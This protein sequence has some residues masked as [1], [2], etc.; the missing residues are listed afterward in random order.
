MIVSGQ[1]L[2]SR[3]RDYFK[4]LSHLFLG[5]RAGQGGI[6]VARGLVLCERAEKGSYLR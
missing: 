2:L 4:H 6:Q 5:Q 3:Q 1:N